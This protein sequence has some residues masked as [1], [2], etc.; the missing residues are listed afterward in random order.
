LT[1]Q[2]VNQNPILFV[3]YMHTASS[4]AHRPVH[5]VAVAAC[6]LEDAEV[7]ARKKNSWN[8]VLHHFRREDDQ[9]KALVK[10]RSLKSP[11]THDTAAISTRYTSICDSNGDK[12]SDAENE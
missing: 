2:F 4:K 8:A 1:A 10:S 6:N 7:P 12:S 9:K 3:Y 5:P 11:W